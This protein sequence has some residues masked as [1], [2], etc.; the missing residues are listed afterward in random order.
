M[1]RCADTGCD[2]E[3]TRELYG[4]AMCEAYYVEALEHS[5]HL[6]TV[7]HQRVVSEEIRKTARRVRAAGGFL[8]KHLGRADGG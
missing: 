8:H 1:T 4:I 3:A 2:R 7:E 5:A 6:V